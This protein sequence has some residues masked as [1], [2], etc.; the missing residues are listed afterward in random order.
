MCG[1][2]IPEGRQICPICEKGEQIDKTIKLV[3]IDQFR[4]KLIELLD[5]GLDQIGRGSLPWAVEMLADHLIENGV[6]FA[7]DNNVGSKWISVKD[8]LP[9]TNY[10]TMVIVCVDGKKSAARWFERTTIRGKL[11]ERFK[12]PWDVITCENITH[13]MPL[14]QPPK[15]E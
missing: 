13:W 12:Y 10:R 3:E 2:I 5:R 11:V 8:R 7:T 9:E 4:E 6:T 15:G 1:R 14:P